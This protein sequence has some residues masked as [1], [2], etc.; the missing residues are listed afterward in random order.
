MPTR[1]QMQTCGT[2]A[3]TSRREA[4][5][6]V[7]DMSDQKAP[8]DDEGK[9]RGQGGSRSRGFVGTR[10]PPANPVS[11]QECQPDRDEMLLEVEEAERRPLAGALQLGPDV[12]AKVQVQDSAQ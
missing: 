8:P 10:L 1:I 4:S 12:D 5:D 2:G 9:D 7:H 6:V 3:R 11:R